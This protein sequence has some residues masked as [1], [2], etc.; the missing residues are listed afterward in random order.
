MRR[1]TSVIFSVL[2]GALAVGI[3]TVPYLVLAN[4]DRHALSNQLESVS[5]HASSI[6]NEKNK[7]AEEA[8]AKVQAA[9]EEI[10]RAQSILTDVEQDRAAIPFA[11]HLSPIAPKL[12]ISWDTAV[13]LPLGVT[14]RYPSGSH[15][16]EDSSIKL[17]ISK[18]TNASSSDPWT[19][20]MNSEWIRISPYS[21]T[22]Y[23]SLTS[24]FATSTNIA[25]L[26]GTHLMR[27]S[28]GTLFDGTRAEILNVRSAATSTHIIWVHELPNMSIAGGLERV[29]GT[30]QFSSEK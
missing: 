29:L 1:A 16:S 30:L 21:K 28:V 9:N 17:S 22:A 11:T 27:G 6:E 2:L 23:D 18:D 15:V 3:G 26:I 24:Q 10:A 14:I 19:A 5:Q 13:S 4:R 20:P 25:Y 7:I 8:N 12:I